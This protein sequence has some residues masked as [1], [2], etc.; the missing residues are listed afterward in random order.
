LNNLKRKLLIGFGVGL[1]V[2][3]FGIMA[4]DQAGATENQEQVVVSPAQ[5]AVNT[6]LGTATTEVQQAID[7]T[8]SAATQVVE[9]QAELS[10]E[11]R[12]RYQA[13]HQRY[14]QHKQV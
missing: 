9:A 4:P 8:T 7:A 14:L 3:V 13:Y 1:C 5:Q 10:Q 6:A 12:Q 2:T 11:H